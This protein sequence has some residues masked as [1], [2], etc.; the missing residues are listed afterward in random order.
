VD[1]VLFEGENMKDDL[2]ASQV[3]AAAAPSADTRSLS[4][5]AELFPSVDV[6]AL[7]AEIKRLAFDFARTDRDMHEAIRYQQTAGKITATSHAR[8][9]VLIALHAAIDSLAALKR[10]PEQVH[11]DGYSDKAYIA[12][13]EYE[14]NRCYLMQAQV[15]AQD[16]GQVLVA[17]AQEAPQ[18]SEQEEKR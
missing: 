10:P 2:A 7:A 14:L 9:D 5:V 13:L 8:S 3:Q 17:A 16:S 1:C 18:T 11:P 6:D 4:A 15:A 12:D